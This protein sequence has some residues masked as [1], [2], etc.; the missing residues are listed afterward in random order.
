MRVKQVKLK[1]WKAWKI[2]VP[3]NGLCP[4]T[5]CLIPVRA[6]NS[7]YLNFEINA[8]H[9]LTFPSSRDLLWH[10]TLIPLNFPTP[11]T[12]HSLTPIPSPTNHSRAKA[13]SRSIIS[14]T[15]ECKDQDTTGEI[16][17]H[18]RTKVTTRVRGTAGRRSTD[19]GSSGWSRK[20]LHHHD[21]LTNPRARGL[22]LDCQQD[23]PLSSRLAPARIAS[24]SEG[25]SPPRP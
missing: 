11:K 14:I 6:Q 18:G 1:V 21:P 24:S 19:Q 13:K 23:D 17:R 5:W 3:D 8:L 25:S 20:D 4:C 9:S 15:I 12:S 22:L 2:H 16:T 7:L 10:S